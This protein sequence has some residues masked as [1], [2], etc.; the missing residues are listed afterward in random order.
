MHQVGKSTLIKCMVK[1]YTKQNLAE[2][3]GPITV[4]A[5]ALGSNC[6]YVPC[7]CALC[8]CPVYA[9]LR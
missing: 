7:V 2:V 9:C 5:G 3:K 8:M 4:V 1:H 6:V